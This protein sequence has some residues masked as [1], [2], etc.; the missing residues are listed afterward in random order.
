MEECL[1]IHAQMLTILTMEI[2]GL[3]LERL[4]YWCML[5]IFNFSLQ[6]CV[7]TLTVSKW[8]LKLIKIVHF[9]K[10]RYLP[11][12]K[13]LIRRTVLG[14]SKYIC[15]KSR[16]SWA[17]SL[18]KHAKSSFPLLS[19]TEC[20]KYVQKVPPYRNWA[21]KIKETKVAHPYP[22]WNFTNKNISKSC[23]PVPFWNLTN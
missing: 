7:C 9:C 20:K 11:M 1:L 22:F 19:N 15:L 4:E 23:P 2:I 17:T 12:Y 13:T 14:H 21:L 8:I 18:D 6:L 3:V 16:P 5:V 10:K